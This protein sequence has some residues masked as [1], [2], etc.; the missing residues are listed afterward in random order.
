[1]IELRQR[2]RRRALSVG[3][4]ILLAGC[5][6]LQPPIGPRTALQSGVTDG[7]Q[8]RVL[9]AFVNKAQGY[10]PQSVIVANGRVYGLTLFGGSATMPRCGKGCGVIFSMALDGSAYKVLHRFTGG[11]DGAGPFWIFATGGSL[12][13]VTYE[14]GGG[15]CKTQWFTGCGTAFHVGLDGS[16]YNVLHR[17]QNPEA[18]GSF[19]CGLTAFN[20]ELYGTTFAGGKHRY[21]T[22]FKVSF[23]GDD[24]SVVHSFA[25]NGDGASPNP[26]LTELN[27]MLFGTTMHGGAGGYDDGTVFSIGA[28]SIYK[29]VY[30]TIFGM[31][32]AGVIPLHGRLFGTTVTGGLP[33]CPQGCGTIY[34]LAPNGDDFKTLRKF[35]GPPDAVGPQGT[36][37]AS[38]GLIYGVST[39]GGAYGEGTVFRISSS[40]SDY[41]IVYS[42]K[43]NREAG[44]LGIIA[45][46]GKYVYGTAAGGNGGILWRL[47]VP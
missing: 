36:L 19:P 20:G 12:Y 27:G 30:S 34:R 43:G 38:G 41:E 2:H 3:V 26:E 5:G 22:T 9:H 37:V 35:S 44:S 42:F 14:G 6:A 11:S 25:G 29:S 17:F 21:G 32:Y 24:F 15:S 33:D 45:L 8:Y 39:E 18:S 23:S 40:G 31:P 13:G 1:M 28:H 4:A 16:N 7:G 46:A 10:S 47:P